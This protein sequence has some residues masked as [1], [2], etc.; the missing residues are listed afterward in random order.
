M[1]SEYL[2]FFHLVFGFILV[3]GVVLAAYAELM[4]RR[5]RDLTQF[6]VYLKV[7]G[8]GGMLAGG[9]TLLTAVFGILTAWQQN[10]PLTTTGW[11]S[12]TYVVVIV[13]FITPLLTLKR[14]GDRAMALMP[15]AREKGEVL[16]EQMD[17][18]TGP[19]ARVAGLFL[20]GLLIFIIVMMVFKPF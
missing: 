9:G 5:A 7:G 14:Y 10:W 15:E 2:K 16:P 13:A 11:L 1:A 12:A 20:W 4:A 19:K 18:I 8:F 17:L 3:S 6:E